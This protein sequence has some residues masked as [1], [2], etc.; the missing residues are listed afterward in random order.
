MR[1]RGNSDDGQVKFQLISIL[2]S[3]LSL[4]LVDMKLVKRYGSEFPC[5][6]TKY[7]NEQCYITKCIPDIDNF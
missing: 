7:K 4:T 1:V 5:K 3:F 6:V 2:K